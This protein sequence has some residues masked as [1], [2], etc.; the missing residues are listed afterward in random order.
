MLRTFGVSAVRLLVSLVL[1]TAWVFPG[2]AEAATHFR[3]PT[4]I[5]TVPH[6][7]AQDGIH[8][9][10]HCLL[11]ASAVVA[12]RTL[13]EDPVGLLKPPPECRVSL[14]RPPADLA[15][16]QAGQALSRAPPT[17]PDFG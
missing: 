16:Q 3:Q 14:P 2:A 4:T 8:H 11:D 13:A 12:D 10:D 6:L 5:Q 7:E 1:A 17:P 15:N 9:A